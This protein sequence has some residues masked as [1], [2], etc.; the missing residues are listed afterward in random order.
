MTGNQLSAAKLSAYDYSYSYSCNLYDKLPYKRTYELCNEHTVG[1]YSG[2]VIKYSQ[3]ALDKPY[4]VNN[5]DSDMAVQ[6]DNI[7][8]TNEAVIDNDEIDVVNS[9]PNEA[10]ESILDD[11]QLALLTK[12][13]EVVR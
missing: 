1:M 3:Y 5:H 9:I 4:T 7:R 11:E 8:L 10:I 6:L 12:D 2:N 13:N